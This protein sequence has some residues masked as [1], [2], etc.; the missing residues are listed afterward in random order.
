VRSALA[1]QDR[2]LELCAPG[3]YIDWAMTRLDRASCLTKSGETT[4]ALNYATETLV[5][6][7]DAQRQ[8]IIT[9]R[10]HEVLNS[11]PKDHQTVSAARDLRELLLTTNEM[12]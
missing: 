10:G 3:D 6:L 9:M 7:S 8:G 11:L 4:D 5:A 1:A 2:A 12:R